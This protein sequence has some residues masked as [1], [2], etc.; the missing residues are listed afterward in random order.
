MGIDPFKDLASPYV[1]LWMPRSD[2]NDYW[3][4]MWLISCF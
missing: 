1:Y 2:P 4:K 3:N